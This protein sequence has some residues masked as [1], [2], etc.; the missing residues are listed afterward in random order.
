M[1]TDT[2]DIARIRFVTS[3]YRHLQGLRQ[4]MWIA[5]LLVH[6][7]LFE[8]YGIRPHGSLDWAEFRGMCL[9]ATP[10]LLAQIGDVWLRGYY[11]R[12]FGHVPDGALWRRDV[13]AWLG[14]ILVGIFFDTRIFRGG[15]PS[16]LLI[17]IGLMSLHAAIRDWPWRRHHLLPAMV[18]VVATATRLPLSEASL[19][20]MLCT[21]GVA[22]WLDH[23]L[24]VRTLPPNPDACADQAGGAAQGL[25]GIAAGAES[26]AL[27]DPPS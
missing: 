23:R 14:L 12:R 7:R 9:V 25:T 13:M 20:I 27:Q 22:A 18:S 10:L 4:L 6:L 5:G 19:A 21:T 1:Q 24:L 8:L 16:V 15:G 2:A 17:A 11:S 26:P 3:R